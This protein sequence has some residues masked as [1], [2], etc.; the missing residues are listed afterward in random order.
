MARPAVGVPKAPAI[1]WLQVVFCCGGKTV[2]D[3]RADFGIDPHGCLDQ[4]GESI[5]TRPH[6]RNGRIR[7]P[8]Q[9]EDTQ[10]TENSP[11][12]FDRQQ[13]NLRNLA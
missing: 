2:L 4:S 10:F 8:I 11:T 1:R 7:D 12:R 5:L 3:P 13:K 9:S 6:Q